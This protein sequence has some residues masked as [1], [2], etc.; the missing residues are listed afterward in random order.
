M[1]KVL[2]IDSNECLF[3]TIKC[4]DD[5]CLNQIDIKNT[6]SIDDGINNL[7][8]EIYDLVITE[9]F[10]KDLNEKLYN[11]IKNKTNSTLVLL[12]SE[13]ENIR[14]KCDYSFRKPFGKGKILDL[15]NENY[16]NLQECSIKI[17]EYFIDA[18]KKV[19]SF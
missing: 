1:K 14:V 12:T 8:V 3:E 18:P 6:K 9:F 19:S 11:F 2:L 4:I 16:K 5:I 7:K 10:S 13:S 15:I 17:N